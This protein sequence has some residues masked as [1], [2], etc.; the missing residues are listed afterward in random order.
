[1]RFK[2]DENLS[3]TIA[4][5]LA[6]AGHDAAT[7][8]EQGLAGAEDPDIAAVCLDEDRILLTLDLDFADV[9]AYPPQSY[10]GLMV[11]RIS[12]QS[13][14]R[15]LEAVSRILPSLSGSSLRG[16][17]WVVEDSRIRIRE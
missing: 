3:P 12:N 11:L 2:L 10:P 5:L 15:Q 14:R 4:G 9:R 13:P 17:L 7:V 8:A 16:Q 1:M 6:E